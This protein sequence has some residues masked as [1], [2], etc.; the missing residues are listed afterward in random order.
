LEHEQV[1][2]DGGCFDRGRGLDLYTG[3]YASGEADEEHFVE[4]RRLEARFDEE[5]RVE[6]RVVQGG[7]PPQQFAPIRN[8]YSRAL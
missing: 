4:E 5:R 8:W 3:A 1:A 2:A 7:L 6:D